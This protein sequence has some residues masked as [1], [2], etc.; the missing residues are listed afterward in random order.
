MKHPLWLALPVAGVVL[1]AG[2]VPAHA[3]SQ[4]KT[5]IRFQPEGDLSRILSEKLLEK[6]GLLEL[7][8]VLERFHK[9]NSL[10]FKFDG[11][12]P[13]KL[14][15]RLKRQVE[16]ILKG[17]QREHGLNP[18]GVKALQHVLKN[19]STPPEG[20]EGGDSKWDHNPANGKANRGQG[21]FPAAPAPPAPEPVAPEPGIQEKLAE[22]AKE[23]A[24]RLQHT[25]FGEDLRNSE[26]WQDVMRNLEGVLSDSGGGKFRLPGDGLGK[27]GERLRLPDWNL[28]LPDLSRLKLP[29]P[30][31]P[32]LPRPELNLSLPRMNLGSPS[33]D[34]GLPSMG[35][36]SGLAV[37]Q[38]L[39]WALLAVL[40]GGLLWHLRARVALARHGAPAGWQLGPWPVNPAQIAT[41]ADLVLAF[42]YLALLRLGREARAW[43][44]CE[45]AGQ[46]GGLN[47]E[48]G[49]AAGELASLY[50]QARYAP[51]DEPLA[52]SDLD[53]A[54][55]NLCLLAG[56]ATV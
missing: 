45:I 11:L 39:L 43:N 2:A 55:R 18:E 20:K 46:L 26:K 30:S 47:S 48:Q 24:E 40:V 44:H 52:P 5:Y 42:E 16:D 36:A 21:P 33:L 41:R 3:Q 25:R 23:F 7:D 31:L 17:N 13:R 53:A 19:A 22:W 32:S 14:D 56:V 54:R 51:D 12:D 8:K 9:N 35:G 6:R 49:R 38:A 27:L 1:L 50:E 4:K 15:P 29:T 37:S 10:P 28:A 34:G